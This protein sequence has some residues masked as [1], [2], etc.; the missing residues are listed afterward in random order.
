MASTSQTRRP[1][2]AVVREVFRTAI[3]GSHRWGVYESTAPLSMRRN[4][5][6]RFVLIVYPPG[7]NLAERRAITF[8]RRWPAWGG[9]ILLLAAMIAARIE[10]YAT[11]PFVLLYATGILVGFVKTRRLRSHTRR[12][13]VAVASLGG[14]P[15]VIGD[16]KLLNAS[17]KSLVELDLQLQLGHLNPVEHEVGWGRVYEAIGD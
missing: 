14:Q 10:P 16:A 9:M 8:H 17:V 7:T 2:S 4:G 11:I 13:T 3:N 12:L 1:I 6:G 5:W 15:E